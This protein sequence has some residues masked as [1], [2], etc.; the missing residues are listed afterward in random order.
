LCYRGWFLL[1]VPLLP[2]QKEW[3]ISQERQDSR[4]NFIQPLGTW[5][6]GGGIFSQ[7]PKKPGFFLPRK[8]VFNPGNGWT[9]FGDNFWGKVFQTRDLEGF[10]KIKMGGGII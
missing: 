2:T 10:G 9:G 4:R 7:E 1:E 3:V 6:V 8:E 5:I